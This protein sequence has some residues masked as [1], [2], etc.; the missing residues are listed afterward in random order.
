MYYR[1]SR[2]SLSESQPRFYKKMEVRSWRDHSSEKPK[3]KMFRLSLKLVRKSRS[4]SE[5]PGIEEKVVHGFYRPSRLSEPARERAGA[6][7]A[8]WTWPPFLGRAGAWGVKLGLVGVLLGA[9]VWSKIKTTDALQQMSGLTLAK[10]SVEGVHYLTENQVLQADQVPLGQNMFKLDLGDISDKVKQLSWADRVFVE[11][12]LPKSLL[13]SVRERKPAALLDNGGLY[14][15]DAQG[16]ILSPSDALRGEDLPVISGLSFAPE[17]VGT[18]LS[19][20]A[21]KP[22]LDFLSFLQVKDGVLAQDVSEVN[23]SDPD[24]LKVTF[25][26][27]ITARFNPTVT[28]TELRRMA[29]V[30]SDLNQKGKRAAA[31]DF[32]Y[33]NE[34]LVR[35]T[36]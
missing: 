8:P 30:L 26:D 27:G 22:A 13:I 24:C 36:P 18:T 21:L 23:L 15:V 16:R 29:M 31:L 19:A 12:R 3:E 20:A 5:R 33:Q 34:V 14:A 7:A 32:R 1:G 10:I 4:R 11:R 9:L 2:V 35:T 6:A 28:D 25:M 17:A